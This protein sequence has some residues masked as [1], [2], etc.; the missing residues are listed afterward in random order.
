MSFA[1]VNYLAVV[2]AAAASF[3]FGGIW[4]GLFS[5]PWLRA[6]NIKDEDIHSVKGSGAMVP[7]VT[8]FFAQLV[9]A[10]FLAGLVGHLGQSQVT[11]RNGAISAVVVW[12]GFVMPAMVVNHSFQGAPKELTLIDGGHWLGVLLLQGAII[13][14]LGIG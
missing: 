9:M 5:A 1:G 12:A 6:A 7:Y 13:G 11:F 3:V 8:A 4:Y 10:L 14:W 2:V